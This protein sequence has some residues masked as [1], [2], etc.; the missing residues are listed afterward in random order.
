[1]EGKPW[2]DVESLMGAFRV[3]C[4]LVF[5]SPLTVDEFGSEMQSEKFLSLSAKASGAL[6]DVGAKCI[7]RPGS[8]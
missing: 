6:G 4:V 1:V 8:A 3:T 2:L 5:Q 7:S